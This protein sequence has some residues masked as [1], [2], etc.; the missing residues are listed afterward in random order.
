MTRQRTSSTSYFSGVGRDDPVVHGRQEPAAGRVTTQDKAVST[1]EAPQVRLARR[2][3]AARRNDDLAG[4]E[5]GHRSFERGQE[6]FDRLVWRRSRH[7]A[8]AYEGQ[9]HEH[10]E[11]PGMG[12][13]IDVVERALVQGGEELLPAQV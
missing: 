5:A 3:A 13:G 6:R 11:Q 10:V 4:A 7:E 1:V 8:S 9:G 12:I 2:R